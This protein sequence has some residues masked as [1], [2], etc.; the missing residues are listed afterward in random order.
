[1]AVVL[2]VSDVRR[3][4]Y[5]AAGAAAPSAGDGATPLLGVLFHEVL[6]ELVGT[7][8]ER[9]LRAALRDAEREPASQSAELVRHV[10][11]VL[12]GPRLANHQSHLQ[13]SGAEVLAFWSAVQAACEWL[14]E[15]YRTARSTADIDGG[16]SP[17]QFLKECLFPEEPLALELRDPGWT[18]TVRLAGVSD[19]VVRLP[20]ARPWCVV[21]FKLGRGAP[22]ADLAQACLY[23]QMLQATIA[24]STAPAA[25]PLVYS[26]PTNDHARRS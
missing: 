13:E 14:L 3:E 24:G 2:N 22:E 9:S 4:I 21:E 7:D 6:A 11:Q 5:R 8:P 15:L 10:Y 1:M 20:G 23:H 12:V 25:K 16:I 26:V 19:L 18:D 17:D